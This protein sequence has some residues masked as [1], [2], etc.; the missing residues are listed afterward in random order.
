MQRFL[1][2]SPSASQPPMRKTL[3]PHLGQVPFTA[4]LPFFIVICCGFWISTFIL[5]F[6]QYA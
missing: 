3:V 2:L 4:G 6:T 1:R 5:S